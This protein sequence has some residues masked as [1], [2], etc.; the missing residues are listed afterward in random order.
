M[1]F[2][3][4]III[5]YIVKNDCLRVLWFSNIKLLKRQCKFMQA[6]GIFKCCVIFSLFMNNY[7]GNFV[8]MDHLLSKNPHL[9]E[10]K[11]GLGRTPLKIYDF[12]WM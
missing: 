12:L 2:I 3:R 1:F 11:Q 6:I 4:M 9:F 8:T 10:N 7:S 5:L